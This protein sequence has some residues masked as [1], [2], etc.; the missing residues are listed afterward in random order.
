MKF[1]DA[2]KELLAG[3][4]IYRPD[5]KQILHLVN[6]EPW[7]TIEDQIGR[8]FEPSHYAMLIA[9]WEI[10]KEPMSSEDKCHAAIF[11]LQSI[12]RREC[13]A[14]HQV[15]MC[16]KCYARLILKEIGEV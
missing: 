4:K 1:H 14:D 15:E 10:Y 5:D 6:G 13:F 2:L 11:A 7:S 9:E 16:L 8:L 12:A 3:K